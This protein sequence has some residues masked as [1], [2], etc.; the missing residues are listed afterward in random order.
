MIVSLLHAVKDRDGF[1]QSYSLNLKGR[2]STQTALGGICTLAIQIATL[3]FVVK[4][5]LY[6]VSREEPRITQ[7]EQGVNLADRNQPVYNLLDHNFTI[8][9]SASK[10]QYHLTE[11]GDWTYNQEYLDI[12]EFAIAYSYKF[13]QDGEELL[14]Q[15]FPFEKCDVVDPYL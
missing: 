6:M 9:I 10:W 4:R 7:V 13:E 15:Y 8:G 11:D 2:G 3:F 5:T 14:E 12:S 1:G